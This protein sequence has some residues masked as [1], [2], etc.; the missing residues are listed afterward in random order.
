MLDSFH[1]PRGLKIRVPDYG[2]AMGVSETFEGGKRA[3]EA[4]HSDVGDIVLFVRESSL[5]GKERGVDEEREAGSSS[6]IV[7]S[8]TM[9]ALREATFLSFRNLLNISMLIPRSV[10]QYSRLTVFNLLKDAGIDTLPRS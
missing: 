9:C 8:D 10:S 5:V 1:H 2:A 7:S 6:E 3:K 4:N